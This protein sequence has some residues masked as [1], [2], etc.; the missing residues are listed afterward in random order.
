MSKARVDGHVDCPP[1]PSVLTGRC[2]GSV[3]PDWVR[4]SIAM[5]NA[6]GP[7]LADTS[8]LVCGGGG[9]FDSLGP[10]LYP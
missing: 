4:T 6:W 2:P 5:S 8:G 3:R 1:P 7:V 9:E 10:H